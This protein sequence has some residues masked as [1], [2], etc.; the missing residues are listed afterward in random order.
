MN[1]ID[2]AIGD[3]AIKAAIKD[4]T[5][6]IIVSRGFEHVAVQQLREMIGVNDVT[7][8]DTIV[9][10]KSKSWDDIFRFVYMS[11]IANRIILLIDAVEF[12]DEDSILK[13]IGRKLPSDG[14]LRQ[15]LVRGIEGFRVSVKMD[16]HTD[17][18]YLE[19]E[20]GGVIL[21]F[22][23][24]EGQELKVNLK[25]PMMNF[26]TYI[27]NGT[28]YL[29]IDLSDDLTKRDYKIFNNAVSLKGPT[30]FGLLTLAGYKPEDVYMNPYC[31]SGTLEIEAAL[32]A[33]KTSHRHY[34]KSFPFMR[35]F[36][37]NWDVFFRKVD[38]AHIEKSGGFSITGADPLLSSITAAVKNAKIAGMESFIDF[39]RIDLDWM[40][41]K[42]EEKSVD[43]MILFHPG[44]SKS[45][46][47]ISKDF[48]QLFY[49]AAYI[50]KDTGSL[51]IMCLSKDLLMRESSEYLDMDHEL[52]V[53]SGGQSMHVLFFKKKD[54]GDVKNIKDVEDGKKDDG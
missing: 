15:Q 46:R 31:Y 52:H 20:I 25:N 53:S 33:T 48:K 35:F 21:D 2:G 34:N 9:L 54:I 38:S 5:F 42:F 37:N 39:R 49:Q 10:F 6:G 12:T 51:V 18:T 50:L 23:K 44:S 26:Y 4:I 19:S 16:E 17:V 13:T 36:D 30:A 43:K 29:G 8:E 47:N 1:D 45:A 40:D 41:I 28:A 14:F 11:Q 32:Y 7:V 24:G 27:H 22:A 3:R